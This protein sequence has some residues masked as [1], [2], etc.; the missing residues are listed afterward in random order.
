MPVKIMARNIHASCSAEDVM[1]DLRNKN[2]AIMEVW[3]IRSRK[4]KTPLPL[5]IYTNRN[6]VGN[7]QSVKSASEN[8]TRINDQNPEQS[9]PKCVNCGEV[10]PANYR[11][12]VVAKELQT[13]DGEYVVW[14]CKMTGTPSSIR[15]SPSR[16]V[17]CAGSKK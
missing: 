13:K 2:L 12:C 6:I 1:K 9:H 4:D 17:L 5:Y 14:K 11:G 16:E 3:Q 15:T 10:H 8:T 7:M